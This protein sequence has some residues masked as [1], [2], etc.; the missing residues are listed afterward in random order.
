[1]FS[2]L[3]ERP[4]RLVVDL[5]EV[6]LVEASGISSLVTLARVAALV[7]VELSLI[8]SLAFSQTMNDTGLER[9]LHPKP[10]TGADIAERLLAD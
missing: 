2:A 4:S 6:G 7:Q 8:P 3:G 1:M 10:P 5:S 9:L